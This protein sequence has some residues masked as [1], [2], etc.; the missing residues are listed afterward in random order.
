MSIRI[1]RLLL[2]LYPRDLRGKWEEEIVEAFEAQ[3]GDGWLNAWS[4]AI[5]ELFQVALPLRTTDKTLVIPL[6]SVVANG[7]L[8]FGLIWALG[9]SMKMLAAYHKLL[10][11]LGG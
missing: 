9:N 1:Y 2:R 3:L 11:T 6:V 5:M 8:F 7:M 10:A 4:C